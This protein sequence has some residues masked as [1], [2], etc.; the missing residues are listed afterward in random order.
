[1]TLDHVRLPRGNAETYPYFDSGAGTIAGPDEL[2]ISGS[3]ALRT[4]RE[5]RRSG[6]KS[7]KLPRGLK[8]VKN[9]GQ[10]DAALID[11]LAD[12][13]QR[14]WILERL[15]RIDLNGVNLGWRGGLALT[16]ACIEK[17][18]DQGNSG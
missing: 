18:I 12:N 10:P 16:R 6:C 15:P 5:M 13:N 8:C 4:L 7:S 14:L 2:Q 3:T 17:L 1:M 11:L 9:R